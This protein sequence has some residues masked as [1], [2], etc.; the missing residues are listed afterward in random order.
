MRIRETTAGTLLAFVTDR[1]AKLAP[2]GTGPAPTRLPTAGSGHTLRVSDSVAV[3]PPRALRAVLVTSLVLAGTL[4]ASSRAQA[5]ARPVSTSPRTP[6]V[7]RAGLAS[8]SR[9]DLAL[10]DAAYLLTLV[11]LPTGSAPL[12]AE[13]SGDSHLL[14]TAGQSIG[15]PN[16]VDLHS[17][18]VAP[19]NAWTLYRYERSHPPSG[20]TIRGGYNSYGTASTYG[21]TDEWFVSYSWFPVKALLDSRVLVVSIAALPDH[22]SGIRVDAQVTWLPAKPAGDIVPTGAKV[23]TAVLSTGLNPGEP[24]HSPVTTT[25]PKKIEAIRDFVNQLNVVPPGVRFCPVDFGQNLTVSFRKDAQAT[26]FAVVV[27]DVGGCEEVQVLRFGQV[28][29][30]ELSGYGLVQFVERELGFS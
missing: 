2:A 16:L 15:D 7:T 22:R 11:R 29:E 8:P 6:L 9:R 10:R 19:Q 18:F 3:R 13:P 23:L 27:A 14:R 12:T 20:S 28:A 30:P 24:G 5:Q 21:N 26:P 25:N 1:L 17:F 4:A